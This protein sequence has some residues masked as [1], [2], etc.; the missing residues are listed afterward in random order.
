MARSET[1]RFN[2]LPR[3]VA[4]LKAL[5]GS[6]CT[7]PFAVAALTVA[8]LCNYNSNPE[9]TFS[10][11]DAIKGP[12]ALTPYE[13]SF[14]K[15]R[16]SYG[17]YVPISYFEGTSPANSYTPTKPYTITVFDNPY[18]YQDPNYAVLYIKSSGADSPRSVKLRKKGENWYLWEQFVLVSIR[19]ATADDPWA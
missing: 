10:M 12:Q 11:L 16:F 9:E 5:P 14:I 18:S 19:D 17:K 13:K 1:F 2:E 4:E 7:D 15:E 8:V 6:E 3:S